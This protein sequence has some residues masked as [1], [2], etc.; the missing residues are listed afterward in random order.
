MKLSDRQQAFLN[1]ANHL[2]INLKDAGYTMLEWAG[3]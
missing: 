2:G 1:E 3:R